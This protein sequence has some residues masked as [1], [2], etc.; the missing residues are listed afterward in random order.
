MSKPI[1]VFVGIPSRGD[2]VTGTAMAL[3][4][5]GRTTVYSV[6]THVCS[7]LAM[8]FNKMWCMA[9]NERSKF[10]HFVM[11]H[12]D[13]VPLDNGWLD[14]LMGEF[15]SSGADVV[16]S[17]VPIKDDRGLSS[18]AFLNPR[19]ME[20]RRL[21]MNET[22]AIKPKTF[23]AEE[24]GH[25]GCVVL[26]NT[27]LW[28]CDFTKPWV[29]QICFTVRDR[30]FKTE[31]GEWVAQT[32]SEDWDFGVQCYRLGVKV[33]ATRAVNL[34]HKGGFDYPSMVPWGSLKTDDQTSVWCETTA[35]GSRQFNPVR[36]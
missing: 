17:V 34:I 30:I 25:K 19:T 4:Q 26:P 18:T 1:S 21:T 36:K 24:A 5:M 16:S 33:K 12:D 31:S 29:E 9:L 8:S 11:L 20:M 7:L 13:I 23:D 15:L 27:G 2:V 3:I 14:T 28:V 22:H 35:T 32:Y 6:R 10:T